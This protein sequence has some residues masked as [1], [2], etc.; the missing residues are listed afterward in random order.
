[1]GKRA[2]SW[3]RALWTLRWPGRGAARLSFHSDGR[4]F[5]VGRVAGGD[6][7]E[8]YLGEALAIARAVEWGRGCCGP[9]PA[10]W[11]IAD[12]EVSAGRKV[13]Q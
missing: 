9:V 3:E 5:V 6:E 12:V 11:C 13:L 1:M 4:F 10:G 2:G 8:L 7:S